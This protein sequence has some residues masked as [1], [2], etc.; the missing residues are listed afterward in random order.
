M[1]HFIGRSP[2]VKFRLASERTDKNWFG[3]LMVRCWL[4]EAV[5]AV[6]DTHGSQGQSFSYLTS[7]PREFEE[8]IQHPF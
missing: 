6:S 2:V 3:P 1:F 5:G 7:Q 8:L 4:P